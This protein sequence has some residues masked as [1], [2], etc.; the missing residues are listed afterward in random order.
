MDIFT[1]Q[2]NEL[3]EHVI[4][5]KLAELSDDEKNKATLKEIAEQELEHYNFWK[6]ITGK[7]ALPVESRIKKHIWLAKI[8]GL[9]FSLRLLEMGEAEAIK[10][11]DSVAK[12][13]P[14]ALSIKEDELQHEQKLIDILNDYRLIYAGSIVLGLNDA[15]VEFTGTLAGLT[16][17]FANNRIVGTTGLVMGVAASL[18]MAASGYLSSREEEVNDEINPITAAIYTG[19]SYLA[20]VAFLVLPY[21]LQDN[22]YIAVGAMLAITILIIAGYTY[23]I[24]IAKAVSFKKRF[25]E[26]A[27]ISLG[28]AAI[29]FGIGIL[30]K[31][32]FGIEI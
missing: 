12:K 6:K 26:M 23:Y 11:Y 2:Q 30:V 16:F 25:I 29:S 10:F 4:Y 28:V 20:T 14:E 15:L 1:Q 13:H 18:S 17:A 21:L 31:K 19:V 7:E 9:S 27:L 32:A 5:S 24:S 22:P 8:F 3:T